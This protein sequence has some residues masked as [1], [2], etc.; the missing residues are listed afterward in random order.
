MPAEP[1]PRPRP[2]GEDRR[3]GHGAHPQRSRSGLMLRRQRGP[4]ARRRLPA[5]LRGEPVRRPAP[6]PA[7]LRPVRGRAPLDQAGARAARERGQG[8]QLALA[9][10]STRRGTHHSAP[11]G[12]AP[13]RNLADVVLVAWARCRAHALRG[14]RKHR[15]AALEGHRPV[16]APHHAPGRSRAGPELPGRRTHRGE[17]GR[18]VREPADHGLDGGEATA[19]Q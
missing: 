16:D 19:E 7:G 5:L 12:L 4:Y 15:R 8:H 17:H 13:G 3:P 6:V 18:Q 11:G 10:G 14:C 9:R 1:A 2:C